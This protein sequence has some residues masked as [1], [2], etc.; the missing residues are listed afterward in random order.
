M[1]PTNEN[2]IN[3]NVKAK[4]L[5]DFSTLLLG[6]REN[7]CV[8][9]TNLHSSSSAVHVGNDKWVY[10]TDKLIYPKIYTA[11]G[12]HPLHIN[13]NLDFIEEDITQ[14]IN[15][16]SL[17][18]IGETGLDEYYTQD[19]ESLQIQKKFFEIHN[20]IA[21]KNKLPVIIHTRNA[22]K[23]TLEILSYYVKEHNLTGV[24]HC[25]SGSKDFA[26]QLLDLNFY[27]SFSG[28]V[29]FNKSK[30]LQEVAKYIPYNYILTE[31]DAP[32]LAPEP[33][34]GKINQ[35]SYVK[36]TAEFL[37]NIRNENINDFT[38]HI[39]NNFFTLFNKANNNL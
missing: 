13:S 21:I 10:Q 24:I 16:K 35:P 20:Q 33:H 14:H 25:F 34:R 38:N 6:R 7:Q 32:Y 8:R 23:D 18:A 9:K 15:R 37:A 19:N 36:H 28:I 12:V 2:Q 39:K 31:T 30:E 3:P 29:T 4:I 17:I 26:K 1:N 22:Q 27:I 11:L 5:T